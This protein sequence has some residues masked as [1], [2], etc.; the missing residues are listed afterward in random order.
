MDFFFASSYLLW[1]LANNKFEEYF[2]KTLG[3]ALK[4]GCNV[5]H[6]SFKH[7]CILFYCFYKTYHFKT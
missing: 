7:Q 3:D 1:K 6:K 5:S 4:D 2:L